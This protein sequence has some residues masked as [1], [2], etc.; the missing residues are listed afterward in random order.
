MLL[1]VCERVCVFIL[2]GGVSNII[3]VNTGSNR[4]PWPGGCND[5]KFHVF[6]SFSLPGKAVY[7]Y[8]T[9]VITNY[10]SKETRP[11]RG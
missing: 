5:V 2:V 3:S 8:C 11:R 6:R 10:K 9:T 4:N 7:E 1:C